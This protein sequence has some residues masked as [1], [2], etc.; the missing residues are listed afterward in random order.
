MS[1]LS[2]GHWFPILS[3]R[4]LDKRPVAKTRFGARLVFWR[5]RSGEPVCL[6]DRCAHRGTALSLGRVRA[7]SIECPFHG[8][9]FASNGRCV[10]VPAEG[11][12][13]KIPDHFRVG[14][15][16]IREAD[17]YV[18]NWRGPAVA[19]DE[20]PPLP[21]LQ[22]VA[23]M[24][25]GET[26]YTWNA[27][28]TRAI[29]NVLDYSHLPFVH[30]RSIGAF[31]RDPATRVRV[32]PRDGGFLFYQEKARKNDRQYVDFIYP[33][34]W[35]NR[36]GKS[37]V[38]AATFVPV[39]D[40]RTEVYVRWYHRIP[41]PLHSLVDLWGTFSQYL[42]FNDDLPIVSSQRP[43]NVDDADNDKLVPSDGG[44]VAYRRLRRSHQEELR[45]GHEQPR[46]AP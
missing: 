36:V 44:L 14:T 25:F 13:W 33:N 26:H 6:E 41:R 16:T 42:V 21:E 30:R 7:D 38:M 5:T 46:P 2:S 35:F 3:S 22:I 43:A 37:F 32:E 27:H 24:H 45:A 28:Y 9:R 12:D 39:D 10:R 11:A 29:E 15:R 18:W 8:F 17:G 31:V 23:G 4:E 19:A 34:L 1:G 40:S 20:L